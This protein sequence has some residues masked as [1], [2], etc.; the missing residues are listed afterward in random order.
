MSEKIPHIFTGKEL[1]GKEAGIENDIEGTG[2][3]TK[4]IEV[5]RHGA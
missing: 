4:R 1:D 2:S 5:I 3:N